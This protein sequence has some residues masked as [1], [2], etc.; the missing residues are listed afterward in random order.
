MPMT[1]LSQKAY[2]AYKN[3]NL[4]VALSLAEQGLA[5]NAQNADAHAVAGLV[6][7]QQRKFIDATKNLISAI[8]LDSSIASVAAALAHCASQTMPRADVLQALLSFLSAHPGNTSLRLEI[9]HHLYTDE[10][11]SRE[12]IICE[13]GIAA[14][15]QSA[16]L[17][18]IYGRC[19][20]NNDQPQNAIEILKQAVA[21]LPE[22]PEANYLLGTAYRSIGQGADARGAHL[23]AM[24]QVPFF[25]K[26]FYAY[27]RS[28]R[29]T[30]DDPL[31]QRF[32]ELQG[33]LEQATPEE[34]S[35]LHYG[36]GTAFEAL[37]RFDEAFVHF[38]KGGRLRS[39]S[40]RFD[41]RAMEQKYETIKNAF[42]PELFETL[43]SS[44]DPTPR[45]L[46]IIGMPR[47]GSSL[48][49]QILS[50]HRDAE[51]LGELLDLDRMIEPYLESL[52]PNAVP[53]EDIAASYMKRIVS[54]GSGNDT[55]LID[56]GLHNFMHVGF[57]HLM[58][59]NAVILHCQRDPLDTCF[60]S[61]ALRF[62]GG[63][64]WSNRLSNTGYAYNAYQSMMDH[65]ETVLPG[66][67]ISVNYEELVSD[68]EPQ[69]RGILKACGLPWDPACLDFQ[70]ASRAVRTASAAQ[71]R[72]PINTSS[73]G[74]WKNFEKHLGKLA[75][76][77]RPMQ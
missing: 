23:A 16:E 50:S 32:D 4:V 59:P 13:E 67:V 5:A 2:A 11:Y 18:L 68:F 26:S 65:W 58:F 41:R 39:R 61:F 37:G 51:G 14:G 36:L 22:D 3:S 57:I 55:R 33:V 19:L 73:I 24:V 70:N 44:G 10:A 7:A 28:G 76:S 45:P 75:E 46:F 42:T 74:R 71:V 47:S 8:E 63:H 34:A 30:P 72:E 1:D 25:A 40:Q 21:G 17:K 12:L 53:M 9:A 54:Q 20:L 31:V 64:E 27:F 52:D 66:R 35:F 69:V 60:S 29:A 49:E 48:L 62:A 15:D 6:K 56:K 43:K 38:E 77:V